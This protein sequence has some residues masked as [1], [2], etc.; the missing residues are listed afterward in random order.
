MVKMAVMCK[1]DAQRI[2]EWRNLS[3]QNARTPF[4]LTCEMQDDWYLREVCNRESKHRYWSLMH[5][6]GDGESGTPCWH[7]AGVAGLTDIDGRI[8]TAEV[9]LMVA[10]ELRGRG[11]GGEAFALLLDQAF[12]V[13]NLETVFGECYLCNESLG[14][15]RHMV[16]KWQGE[17]R[18]L[19]KRQYWDGRY[20]DSLWFCIDRSAWAKEQPVPNMVPSSP[21]GAAISVAG[22]P[23]C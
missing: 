12:G 22:D 16:K 5:D 11:I 23:N 9:A 3:I 1:N 6:C 15:W 17:E 20:W 4:L 7:L 18:Y 8:R 14:F 10:P 19:P 2:R 13:Q 21:W